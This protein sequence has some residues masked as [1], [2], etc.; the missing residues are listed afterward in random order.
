MLQLKTRITKHETKMPSALDQK[1]L[2]SR[3]VSEEWNECWVGR[4]Q[5]DAQMSTHVV[6]CDQQEA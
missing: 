4:R 6:I 2:L 3:R 1:L 5:K